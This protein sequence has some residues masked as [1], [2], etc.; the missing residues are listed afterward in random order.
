MRGI[1][2]SLVFIGFA[3][4]GCVQ[5]EADEPPS[6]E[7]ARRLGYQSIDLTAGPPNL[8]GW[9]PVGVADNGAVYGQGFD[10]TD[11]FSVCTFPLV[12]RAKNGQFSVLHPNFQVADVDEKGDVGG[13]TVD[14]PA[15]FF[16]RAAVVKANGALVAFPPLAG[17]LTACVSRLADDR[18]AAINSFDENFA[19]TTYIFDKGAIVPFTLQATIEDLND[20]GQVT[21]FVFTPP[22]RAYRF[23]AATGATTILQPIAGD[24]DSWGMAINKHGQVLGYSFVAGATERIGRWNQAGQF[25][26]SF[27]EGTPE[28]PTVSN[29][30][31]WN[32]DGLIVI[33][34]SFN[35]PNTYLVPAPGVR[36]NLADLTGGGE[37][38]PTLIVPSVNKGG[39]ILGFT[40]DGRAFLFLRD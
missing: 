5:D 24:P 13:C 19:Q 28:F 26:V 15:T 33:S 34:Q 36:L 37:V 16:G 31:A 23:D 11:D 32:E 12:R 2:I 27:V 14:D 38:P 21:G 8:D 6:I 3:A 40:F 39:D 35:D 22:N 17:E 7:E 25:Q 9:A 1:A 29:R 20:H 18:V 10:C 30:L 4:P